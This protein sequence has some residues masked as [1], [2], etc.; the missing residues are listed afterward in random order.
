[1]PLPSELPLPEHGAGGYVTPG[2]ALR[3]RWEPPPPEALLRA[4]PDGRRVAGGR[5]EHDAGGRAEVAIGPLAPGA[6]RLRYETL[7]D[8]GAAAGDWRELIVVGEEARL[9]LPAVLRVESP[10]VRVGATARLLVHSGIP[11][12]TLYLETY[13]DGRLAARRRLR[14]GWGPSVIELPVRRADRGGF[15]VRLLAVRDHELLDLSAEVRVPWEDRALAVSFSRFRDEV[16]PGGRETWTVAVKNARGGAVAGAELLAA[17]ADRSLDLF[18]PYEPPD[19]L[20]RYPDRLELPWTAASLGAAATTWIAGQWDAVPAPPGLRPARLRFLDDLAT[21]Q[22]VSWG[23]L[24]QTAPESVRQTVTVTA[25]TPQLDERR[26][27][28]GTSLSATAEEARRPDDPAP[29][30]PPPP[31]LP[32]ITIVRSDFAETALWQPH[33]LT[34]PDG[35]AVLELTVPDSVTSWNAWVHAVTADLRSGSAHRETQSVKDLMVRP[36]LPRFLREGDRAELKVLVNNAS[37]AS[38]PP[39]SDSAR[40]GL[41]GEVV[42]DLL[43]PETGE[44]LLA[45]F[46]LDPAAARR[47]FA[48]AAGGAADLT[49]AVTAPRHVGPVH[50]R[51]TAVAGGLSDGELRP[52]PILPSRLH[53]AQSRFAA[54]R[55]EETRVLRFADLE[56]DDDPTRLDEQLVVTLDAQ[57]FHSVL[58]A[59]PS[60]VDS[61][62][63]CTEQTLNRFL[64]TG[65]VASLFDRHPALAALATMS[66]ELAARRD[67][68]L[69]PWNAV[70]PNRRMAL[71]ET[72]W[73]AAAA[74]DSGEPEALARVLDPRV[75]RAERDASL[76]RLEQAQLPSGA[77]PWWPGGPPSPWGG[78]GTPSWSSTA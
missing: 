64:S 23:V 28:T 36:Y 7:D 61:P 40:S 72:P 3:P 71:E 67:T 57:L 55:G 48:V 8:F 20:G 56:R 66:V 38:G 33:L 34:G 19:L 13:R 59:L 60:L 70:D 50:V 37:P 46:G 62:Y 51:V 32:P 41:S 2:D 77:F 17:M 22:R 69:E 25:E 9:A 43:D 74:G 53:L 26:I 24:T 39:G 54:L 15:G 58:A 21:G 42:L 12:Q 4:W 49:F 11:G 68:R 1:V 18:A 45:A 27:T 76:A 44:S 63:Q 31:P 47:D 78:S 6:Y 52:L 14:A 73:L 5:A 75:A 16:R 35:T 10:T 29:A 30:P 65:I